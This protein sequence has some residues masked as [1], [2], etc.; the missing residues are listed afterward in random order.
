M[1][2]KLE[3]WRQAGSRSDVVITV[4]PHVTVGN[5]AAALAQRD[6]EADPNGGPSRATLALHADVGP[7]PI[8]SELSLLEAGIRSGSTVEIVDDDVNADTRRS[9][10]VAAKLRVLTGPDAGAEFDVP[11]GTS[12]VGRD[13]SCEI[14][15]SDTLVS[16]RHAKLHVTSVPELVDTN[17]SNGILIGEEQVA[18]IVLRP[19]DAVVLGESTIA[20]S[21]VGGSSDHDHV[22]GTAIP[23]VRSPRRVAPVS[24]PARSRPPTFQ[25][26]PTH[27]GYP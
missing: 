26:P 13:A 18:R 17:S 16:K 15:L 1:K 5:I 12:Y 23:F 6:P 8:P 19:D 7:R 11:V 25:N 9:G 21:M 27:P 22:H 3:L 24:K 2:L 4:E 20:V 10:P 14:R